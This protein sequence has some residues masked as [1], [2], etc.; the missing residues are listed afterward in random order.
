MNKPLVCGTDTY[1]WWMPTIDAMERIGVSAVG[2]EACKRWRDYGEQV[3]SLSWTSVSH[4]LGLTA[5]PANEIREA[6]VVHRTQTIECVVDASADWRS[7]QFGIEELTRLGWAVTV[8]IPLTAMG[9]AHDGLRG[10]S[11]HLQGWWIR[12]TEMR[13]SSPETV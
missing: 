11:A 4:D 3:E 5:F 10:A 6:V 7:L 12:D 9:R 13:F 1:A 8:L 2:R